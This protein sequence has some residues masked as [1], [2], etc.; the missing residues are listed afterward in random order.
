M[1]TVG[2][3]EYTVLHK[4]GVIVVSGRYPASCENIMCKD[5]LLRTGVCEFSLR[6]DMKNDSQVTVNTFT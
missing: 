1:N 5:Y 6:A 3:P 2:L 4:R